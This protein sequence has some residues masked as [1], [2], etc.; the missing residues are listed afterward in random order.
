MGG[1]RV[2]GRAGDQVTS[3]RPDHC[4]GRIFIQREAST[5][6][7]LGGLLRA[8]A[9]RPLGCRATQVFAPRITRCGTAPYRRVNWAL[10]V[11][12]RTD[13]VTLSGARSLLGGHLH[14]HGPQY[15]ESGQPWRFL[16]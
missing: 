6:G 3:G 7:S 16:E 12:H 8:R 2:A 1:H 9:S 15:R 4:G 11:R 13:V 10:N 5:G 14:P